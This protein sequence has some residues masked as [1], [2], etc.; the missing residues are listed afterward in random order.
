MLKHA[1][2]TLQIWS[3]FGEEHF[4]LNI[5]EVDILLTF[6]QSRKHNW[7]DAVLTSRDGNA[8]WTSV[9]MQLDRIHNT[10]QK[11]ICIFGFSFLHFQCYYVVIRSLQDIERCV[12]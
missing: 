9:P 2:E 7:I 1:F 8:Q 3:L 11:Q 12:E 4:R 5:E 6:C 10:V